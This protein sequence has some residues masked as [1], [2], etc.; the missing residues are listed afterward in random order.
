M[1][2]TI[3]EFPTFMFQLLTFAMSLITMII[4]IAK[5]NDWSV[6]DDD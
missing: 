5:S 6:D 3:L 2:M 1:F 4:V